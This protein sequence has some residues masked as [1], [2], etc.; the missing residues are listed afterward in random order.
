[1]FKKGISATGNDYPDGRNPFSFLW[2]R[3]VPTGDGRAG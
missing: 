3:P 2:M 1:M